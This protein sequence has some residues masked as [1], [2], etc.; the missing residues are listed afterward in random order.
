M[1]HNIMDPGQ[2]FSD[3][4][5]DLM[6]DAVCLVHGHAGIDMQIHVHENTATETS[7]SDMVNIADSLELQCDLDDSCGIDG[8]PIR[9]DT[10]RLERNLVARSCDE[11]PDG[12]SHPYIHE[13][14]STS[15]GEER[16][17]RR[18]S[19]EQVR[20]GMLAVGQQHGA[21]EVSPST[22]LPSENQQIDDRGHCQD[23]I[24]DGMRIRHPPIIPPSQ[25]IGHNV[26]C[27]DK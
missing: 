25:R 21:L 27:C 10:G 20:T 1:N 23:Q 13:R 5:L 6:C 16:T 17:H 15:D 26:P 8:S 9:Q 18:E 12:Q 2:F 22:T 19:P 14:P 4:F 24:S 3:L 7:T 11:E